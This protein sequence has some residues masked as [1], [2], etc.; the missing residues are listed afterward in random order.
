VG[1]PLAETPLDDPRGHSW[2]PGT[3]VPHVPLS[4]GRSTLD[5]GGR[6]FALL[7]AGDPAHVRQV[8]DEV[9]QVSLAVERVPDP[10][11]DGMVLVRP[12]G[13][14]GWRTAEVDAAGLSDTLSRLLQQEQG[15][16]Q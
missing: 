9:Q 14:I 10:N 7:T 3:R 5:V 11:L 15:W 8:A 2:A 4:N 12:D 1:E 16:R 6:G 13:V